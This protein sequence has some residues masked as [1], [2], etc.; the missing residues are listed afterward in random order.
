MNE[1]LFKMYDFHALF[2]D[3][4]LGH[5]GGSKNNYLAEL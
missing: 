1:S 4:I 3:F 2:D 5:G